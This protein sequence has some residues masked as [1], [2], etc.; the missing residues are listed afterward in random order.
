MS[1][2]TSFDYVLCGTALSMHAHYLSENW[3]GEEGKECELSIAYIAGIGEHALYALYKVAIFVPVLIL[4]LC[5]AIQYAFKGSDANAMRLKVG[6][7]I[8]GE[9]I[10][11][12][13]IDCLGVLCPPV[14]YKVHIYLKETVTRRYF[15]EW[16]LSKTDL[17][18]EDFQVMEYWARI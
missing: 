14:A 12:V 8:L 17:K 16:G 18:K 9:T 6:V 15:N 13:C 7:L 5:L 4:N 10:P 3:E 2:L 11:A 1:Q